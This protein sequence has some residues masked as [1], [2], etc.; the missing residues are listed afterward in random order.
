[1]ARFRRNHPLSLALLLVLQVSGAA[2]AAAGE[3]GLYD[4]PVLT[5]DPGMHTAKINRV[6]VSATGVYAVSGSDDK[7]VRIWEAPTGRLLHTIRLPQGLGPVGQVFAVAISPDGALVAAGG[8]T[9]EP[10]QPKSIYLFR[11]DTGV[12]VRRLDGLPNVVFH[13]VFSPTSRYLAATLRGTHGLRVYDRDAGWREVARDASY[14][15]SSYGAAFAADGRLATTSYDGTLRLYDRAFRLVAMAKTTKG[16]RPIGLAFTPAGDRLA[17]GYEDTTA[18]SLVDGRALTPLHGPDTSGLDNGHLAT[19]AWSADGATLYAGGRY[20]R[21]G[22]IPVVAWSAAGAGPR[23]ELAAGTNTI[24]SVR[25]LLDGEVL[26]GAT[27]PWLGV[28]DAAG[29]P[30]WAKPPLQADL[31]GQARTLRVSADGGVVDFGYEF[32]GQAPVRFDLARPAL[33]LDPP[34]DGRTQPPEQATLKIADWA[35]T[36]RPTLNGAPLALMPYETSRSLA[37]HPDGQRFVLGTEWS[38]RLFAADGTPLWTRA[39]PAPVWATNI[40]ADGRLVVA[41][42]GDGTLRWH[43]MEDGSELLALFPLADRRNWIAWTPEGVY[44]ATPGAY[45]VLRWHVNRGWDAPAE[46]FPVSEIPRNHRPEVI[47]LVLQ[48]LGTFGA[49]GRVE[50]TETRAAVQ[51]RTGTAVPPGPRLRVLTV[52]VSNYGPAATHLRLAFAAADATEVAAALRNTQEKTGLYAEVKQQRLTDQDA[53]RVS[54]LRGLATIRNA[55]RDAKARGE[56][57]HDLVVVHFS[58][59]GALIDGEF[60]L[61]PYDVDAGD[62]VAIIATALPASTLRQQLE[63]LGEYGR[64]L[65]LLDACRSGGA[66]ANGQALGADATRLRMV[67]GASNVTV[68]TSSSAAELSREDPRWGNGAFTEILLEALS[69]RADENRNG[70][71]SVSELMGYLTDHVPEL[72]NGA[73]RPGVEVR[74]GGHV[75]VAGL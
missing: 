9:G 16:T 72:T 26:V 21:A 33:T 19:I 27:D 71:I 46:E 30:R 47:R 63:G 7:T 17:V 18:V 39:T 6:D 1:M 5:L 64:V 12:L 4:Q 48:E 42:Y 14:G 61:L 70:L 73:Q 59:H 75:F 23:R 22:T 52:G 38:L 66:M 74:F 57:P 60:Y 43:R 3:A 55:M 41:A 51:R 32:G 34:A 31:R 13:L 8:Y 62:P 11:R 2:L 67:L 29:A 15:D 58:G 36:L 54:I 44:A 68:L 50:L 40:T 53:T 24:M 25:P 35:S 20:Q 37:I 56:P 45:G 10:G 65:V 28:L 49:F 69:S